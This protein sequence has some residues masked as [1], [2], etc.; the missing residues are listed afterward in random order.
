MYT[1][2]GYDASA[3]VAEETVAAAANV[4]RGMVRSVLVSGVFG[5]V[6]LCAAVLA[7]P[8]LGDAAAQGDGAFLWILNRASSWSAAPLCAGIAVAQ[9]LCG[10]A[11]VTSASRMA[12]AFARD[13]GLPFSH[14]L[15]RVSPRFRTPDVAIWAVAAA[16]V[17]FTIYTPAYPTITA[18][19]TIFLYIS[20]VLPTAL[21][22]RAYGRTWTAMGPWHLGRWYRPLAVVAV[23]G[24]VALI[25]IGMQPPNQQALWVVGGTTLVLVVLWFAFVRLSFR[26]PPRGVM[27]QQRQGEIAAM[28]RALERSSEKP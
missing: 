22:L 16:A 6:M 8:D 26:G 27:I 18:V 7:A 21:G 20:Y 9:Y 1:M 4:P 23:L 5:C 13:G 24:C 11:T 17:L 28:E 3:H 12:Y 15:R 19:C 2:T 10:L 25:V 14:W